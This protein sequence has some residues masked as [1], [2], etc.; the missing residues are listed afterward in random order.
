M[1]ILDFQV[2]TV[3]I[4][5]IPACGFPRVTYFAFCFNIVETKLPA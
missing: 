5:V 2:E 4:L 3:A 1:H